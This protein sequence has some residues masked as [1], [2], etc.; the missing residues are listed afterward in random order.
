MS[1]LHIV[2]S[3]PCLAPLDLPLSAGGYQRRTIEPRGEPAGATDLAFR[4][5]AAAF[6]AGADGVII[7]RKY[8]EMDL[9]NL[10]GIGRALK[11]LGRS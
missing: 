7:S 6:E 3:T 10:E 4:W 8:S 5:R 11:A 1:R 9:Q 2:T